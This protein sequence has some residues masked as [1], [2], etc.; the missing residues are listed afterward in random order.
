MRRLV[1]LEQDVAEVHSRLF[2]IPSLARGADVTARDTV[3]LLGG[4][5][6]GMPRY[7]NL[8]FPQYRIEN[9]SGELYRLIRESPM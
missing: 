7:A 9:I 1:L 6:I 2:G 3:F 5:P 8:F 4:G